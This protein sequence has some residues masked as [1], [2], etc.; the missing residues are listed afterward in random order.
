MKTQRFWL[1]C[2]PERIDTHPPTYRHPSYESASK[3]ASRLA[4]A[5]PG[6]V[7]HVMSSVEAC[8]RCDIQR[9]EFGPELRSETDIV[10]F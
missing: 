3:E 2:A 4:M 8:V 10:P 1:V 7:F 5:Y 9:V 6:V